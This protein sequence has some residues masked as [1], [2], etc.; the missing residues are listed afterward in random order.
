MTIRELEEQGISWG[1]K[2]Y[3]VTCDY[4][5]EDGDERVFWEGE[6]YMDGIDSASDGAAYEEPWYCE[7][8]VTNVYQRLDGIGIEVTKY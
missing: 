1:G 6:C 7:M 3:V 4:Y 2:V 8:D 5:D